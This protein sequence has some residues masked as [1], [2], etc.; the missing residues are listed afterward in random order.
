MQ[1]EQ[2]RCERRLVDSFGRLHH[3][4]R[5]DL[6]PVRKEKPAT[7]RHALD[8]RSHGNGRVKNVVK[9][10]D[11]RLVL[12]SEE[13]ENGA[14]RGSWLA[15]ARCKWLVVQDTSQEM[16]ERERARSGWREVR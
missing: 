14:R 4:K 2:Q 6:G 7:C 8:A 13:S 5:P 15:E 10:L 9:I 16:G 3:A 1:T 12:M 11:P